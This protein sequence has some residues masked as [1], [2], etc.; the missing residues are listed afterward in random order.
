MF[1]LIISTTQTVFPYYQI[2]YDFVNYLLSKTNLIECSKR[3]ILCSGLLLVVPEAK[4]RSRARPCVRVR[5]RASM[6]VT[7]CISLKYTY[8]SVSVAI[9]I[10][11]VLVH[12]E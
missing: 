10:S 12:N 2:H 1:H 6:A 8:L 4:F 7:Y 5:E 9:T 11:L 3:H